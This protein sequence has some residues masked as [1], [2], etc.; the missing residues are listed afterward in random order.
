MRINIIGNFQSNTGLTLDSNILRGIL[1][2]VFGKD[3][4]ISCVPHVY[5]QCGEAD[6]NIF[7][8]VINPCLFSYARKNI[9]IPN[10]EW[11]YRSWIPYIEMV[12]EIWVKTTEARKCFNEVSNYSSKI[13]YIG[14]TTIDKGW[15]PD[16]WKKNY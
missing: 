5:P 11:T 2:A 4:Q 8:E 7:L 15:N 16:E 3:V 13:K 10:Q 9:W 1:V 14:W 12:D 6:A